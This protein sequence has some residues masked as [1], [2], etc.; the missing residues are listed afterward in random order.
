M[1]QSL[2]YL[3]AYNG[4]VPRA[5]GVVVG[6]CRNP[7]QFP[8][9]RYVQYVPEDMKL[10]YWVQLSRDAPVRVLKVGE[11]A[12]ADGADVIS[13]EPALVREP[14]PLHSAPSRMKRRAPYPL[15]ATP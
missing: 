2:N 14:R 7:D 4:Y 13:S 5:S 11:A 8:L 12:W 10:F 3:S 6:Y 15:L 9:N 1:P